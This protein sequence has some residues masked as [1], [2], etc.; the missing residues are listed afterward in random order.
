MMKEYVHKKIENYQSCPNS[1]FIKRIEDV[2]YV[3]FDIFDTLIK[4]DVPNPMDIFQIVENISG[5]KN[6]KNKRIAAE[7]NARCKKNNK[8][9]TIDEIYEMNFVNN[10]AYLKNLE[11]KTEI[12]YSTIN[13]DIIEFYEYC[14]KNKKVILIS[15]MYLSKKDIELILKKNNIKGYL[16]LFV[17]NEVERTKANGSLYKYVCNKLNIKSSNLLHIGNSFK[18]DYLQAKKNG[19]KSI[20]IATY[21]RRTEE[22]YTDILCKRNFQKQCINSF[23]NNHTKGENSYYSFGYE[24]FGPLLYGFVNW[25]MIDMKKNEIEQVFFLSRDGFIM[26]KVYKIL[27]FSEEIPD[28]YFEASRRSLRIPAYNRN[29]SY[30]EILHELPVPNRTNLIQIFD[31][32]GLDINDFREVIDSSGIKDTDYLKRDMLEKNEQ[33]RRIYDHIYEDIMFNS[34]KEAQVLSQYLHQFDFSKKTAI[35]DIGWGGSMQKYLITTLN[36]LNIPSNICGYYIGLTEKAKENLGKHRFTA[37]GY[38]F[39][40]LNDSNAFDMERPFVGLFETLF[41]EQSGSVKKYKKEK[42]VVVAERYIYEYMIGKKYTKEAKCVGII[43][44]AALDFIKDFKD[45]GYISEMG[46]DSNIFFSNLYQT[47]VNPTLEDVKLFG[48]FE[49]FNNGSKVYLANPKKL[50]NYIICPK[51]FIRD[52]YDSQWKVGFL[53]GLFKIKLPYLKIFNELKRICN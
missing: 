26:Q 45:L 30:E 6:F 52:M 51:Q 32:V 41:L 50:F 14:V 7:Y 38:A 3:S 11:I 25:L 2:E 35:V 24:R 5:E 18:A 31:S 22:V 23:I 46:F 29:M 28:F 10:S 33:F 1:Q 42:D 49:F 16:Y 34:E 21:K 4:R 39:D 13:L 9:V 8:E 47:G 36:E 48:D 15:D 12:L 17:S 37:K 40:V 53:K 19:I 44:D 43:Q 20:K 27:G